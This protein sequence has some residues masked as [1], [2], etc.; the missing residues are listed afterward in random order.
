MWPRTEKT[1]DELRAKVYDAMSE[2]KINGEKQKDGQKAEDKDTEGEKKAEGEKVEEGEEKGK[3]EQKA[4]STPKKEGEADG[5]VKG[6]SPSDGENK[7]NIEVTKEESAEKMEEGDCKWTCL[8]ENTG[9]M[10]SSHN[11]VGYKMT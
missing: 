10:H 4:K 3:N 11:L 1:R 7:E 8:Q 9:K 5:G 6:A 2:E